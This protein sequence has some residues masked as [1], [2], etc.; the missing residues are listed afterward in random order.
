MSSCLLHR[1]VGKAGAAEESVVNLPIII[2]A[3]N[4]KRALGDQIT[5]Y[6]AVQSIAGPL[7]LAQQNLFQAPVNGHYVDLSVWCPVATNTLRQEGEIAGPRF[8]QDPLPA[9]LFKCVLTDKGAQLLTDKLPKPIVQPLLQQVLVGV[10]EAVVETH[11]SI[12]QVVA[13]PA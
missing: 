2:G 12:G 11:I 7:G 6:L 3:R 9:E 4:N 5:D 8:D 1:C 10:D 13:A